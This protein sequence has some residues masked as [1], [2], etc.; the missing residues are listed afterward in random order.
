MMIRALSTSATGMIALQDRMDVIS[1]NL[2]NVN[3]SGYKKVRANFQDLFY[4]QIKASGFQATEATHSPTGINIGLG[5]KLV[6]TDRIFAQGS[7]VRTDRDLDV[8]IEGDGF[9]Q[10]RLPDGRIAYTRDGA[11]H[12]DSAGQLV[13]A[14]GYLAEPAITIGSNITMV[15][16]SIDG[17]IEGLDPTDPS[18]SQAIGDLTISRFPNPAGLRAIGDN[19]FEE[20]PASGAPITGV[21]GTEGRGILRQLFLEASNVEVVQELVDMITTQRAFEINSNVIQASDQ[22]LQ[23]VNNLRR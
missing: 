22:M 23:T 2:A 16:I 17:R 1:N 7:L 13:T 5:V 19:L 12:R 18:T 10:I 6:S 15:N 3:T 11:F 14:N 9:F 4:Q 20:T 21:P 8:A